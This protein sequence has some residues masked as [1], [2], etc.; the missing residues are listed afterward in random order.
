MALQNGTHD[1]ETGQGGES[2]GRRCERTY[3]DGDDSHG[4]V[5]PHKERVLGQPDEGLG[6]GG[7]E[8]LREPEH[9][10]DKAAHVLGRLGEG[11]LKARDRCA[12]F[13]ERNQHIRG[14]LSPPPQSQHVSQ[15]RFF[16]VGHL[17]K[18]PIRTCC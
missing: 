4:G 3:Q 6:D 1:M 10:C 18:M 15:D 7:R 17:A 9:S 16:H 13:G 11:I 2:W 5:Q 8:G 14:C 12:D